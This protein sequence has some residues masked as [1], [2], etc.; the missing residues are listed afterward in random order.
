MEWVLRK[1]PSNI[2]QA[3]MIDDTDK[4]NSSLAI[5]VLMD[6]YPGCDPIIQQKIFQDL[7]MLLK[8]NQANTRAILECENFLNWLLDI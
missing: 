8:W 3:I 6:F 2:N 7:Y 1:M 4:I 5:N